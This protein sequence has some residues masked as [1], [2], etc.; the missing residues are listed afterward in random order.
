MI[1]LQGAGQPDPQEEQKM[2]QQSVKENFILFAVTCALIRAG[3]E[4]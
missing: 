2:A 1:R 4:S 3:K